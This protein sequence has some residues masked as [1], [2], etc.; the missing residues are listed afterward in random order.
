FMPRLVATVAFISEAW[1]AWESQVGLGS[2]FD[3]SPT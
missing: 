2:L 1:G 3:R